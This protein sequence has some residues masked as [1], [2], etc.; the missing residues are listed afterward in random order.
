MI[1]WIKNAEKDLFTKMSMQKRDYDDTIYISSLKGFRQVNNQHT[2]IILEEETDMYCSMYV[3]GTAVSYLH[4]MSSQQINAIDYF[5][6]NHKV[7]FNVLIKHF[8]KLYTKPK[9]RLGFASINILSSSLDDCCYSEYKFIDDLD[10]KVKILLHK[11]NLV[12]S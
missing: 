4:S 10:K 6:D 11:S 2:G 8:S 7:V 5:E 1:D 12:K 3:D 9:E